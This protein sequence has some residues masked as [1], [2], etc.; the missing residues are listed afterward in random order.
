MQFGKKTYT[1]IYKDGLGGKVFGDERHGN[2]KIDSA[3]PS[4]SNPNSLNRP[5][6]IFVGWYPTLNPIVSA[7]D[8]DENGEIVY[9]A[10]WK[11]NMEVTIVS[12]YKMKENST[13]ENNIQQQA[14]SITPSLKKTLD[15]QNITKLDRN[16]NIEWTEDI[17]N[18]NITSIKETIEGGYIAGGTTRSGNLNN[19]L[20]AQITGLSKNNR[21]YSKIKQRWK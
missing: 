9:T 15:I 13:N 2:R 3:T 20:R 5:G 16:R 21:N 8:A 4:F 12:S 10:S 11:K 14:I 18:C 7:D 17:E 6:Y 1:V 19:I